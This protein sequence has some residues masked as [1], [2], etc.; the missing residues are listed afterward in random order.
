MSASST[1]TER[2]IDGTIVACDNQESHPKS[3]VPKSPAGDTSWIKGETARHKLIGWVIE[4][5]RSS[6]SVSTEVEWRFG[7]RLASAVK[8]RV[9]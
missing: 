5:L 3:E 8:G 9:I 4:V 1:F 7:I 2:E 6:S